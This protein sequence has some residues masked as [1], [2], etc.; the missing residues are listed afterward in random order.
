MSLFKFKHIIIDGRK[1]FRQDAM[2][3]QCAYCL[4]LQPVPMTNLVRDKEGLALGVDLSIKEEEHVKGC[5]QG[6]KK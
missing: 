4:N 5:K 2:T 1:F 6:V 3:Y